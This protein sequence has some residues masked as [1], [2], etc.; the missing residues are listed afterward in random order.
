MGSQV[1]LLGSSLAIIDKSLQGTTPYHC[2]PE[3]NGEKAWCPDPQWA[4][5]T[6]LTGGR[7]AQ[8][9]GEANMSSHILPVSSY[10]V[11]EAGLCP[12]PST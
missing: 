9:L 2:A 7:H 4:A 11:D 6:H 3:V 8:S 10:P 5:W 12:S 1:L